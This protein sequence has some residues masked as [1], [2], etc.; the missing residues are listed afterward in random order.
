MPLLKNFYDLSGGTVINAVCAKASCK[1]K[2]EGINISLIKKYNLTLDG[3]TITSTGISAHGSAPSEGK[4]ALEPLFR[5]F[6]EMGE[7]VQD[8]VSSVFDDKY[9]LTQNH[10][11]QGYITMSPDVICEENG[12]IKIAT[13]IRVPAPFTFDFVKN[14]L[15]KFNVEYISVDK[16]PPFLIDK[17]GWFIQTLI[18]SYNKATGENAKPISMG[19]STFGRVFSEGCSFGIEFLGDS[20][21]IHQPNERISETTIKK[22]YN[23]YYL[24]LKNLVE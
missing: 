4:N 8:F 3:N 2:K 21:Q 6:L 10:N 14:I 7:D 22:A 1:A 17:N 13:D 19:G 12:K 15:D 11:E 16:H 9:K 24:A 18:S 23:V 20:N 5:Y